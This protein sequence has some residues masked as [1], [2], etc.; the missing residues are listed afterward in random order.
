MVRGLGER[1]RYPLP[2]GDVDT[3]QRSLHRRASAICWCSGRRSACQARRSD[4]T[5]GPRA[6]GERLRRKLRSLERRGQMPDAD[7][8]RA[9]RA[10]PVGRLTALSARD[11]GRAA[12]RRRWRRRATQSRMRPATSSFGSTGS[13]SVEARPRRGAGRCW[14]RIRSP[15][16]GAVTSLA[17]IRSRRFSR[18]LRRRFLRRPS[19]VSAAKPT[20]SRRPFCAARPRQDV[21][22][23]ARARATNGPRALLQLARG[24]RRAAG[25]RRPRPPSR[26]P[27]RAR[28]S[29]SS[30]RCIS[31]AVVDRDGAHARRRRQ[32]RRP[33]SPAPPRR[34]AGARRARSHSPSCRSS[35]S[36]GSAPGSIASRV[37]PAET[38]TRSPRRSCG[39]R[40]PAT[41]STISPGSAS[42]PAP[43]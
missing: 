23:C 19:C 26:A 12:T 4:R 3:L 38:R 14:C 16:P 25:S 10:A 17:T 7:R 18:S 36:T 9:G 22:A 1:S 21:R 40:T 11:A 27:W 34:R 5:R 35:G 8:R 33:A 24:R 2:P 41:A 30:A 39:A 29:A 28:N 15:A 13:D 6:G 42:R 20:T 43:S 31:S 32:R 37:G